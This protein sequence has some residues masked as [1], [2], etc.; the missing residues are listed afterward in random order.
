MREMY[1][2]TKK[3][4]IDEAYILAKYDRSSAQAQKRSLP[5]PRSSIGLKS[6]TGRAPI[7]YLSRTRAMAAVYAQAHAYGPFGQVPGGVEP[8]KFSRTLSERIFVGGRCC[9]AARLLS[10][11]DLSRR[12]RF[13]YQGSRGSNR[14]KAARRAELCCRPRHGRGNAGSDERRSHAGGIVCGYALQQVLHHSNAQVIFTQP[15]QGLT[16]AVSRTAARPVVEEPEP[17]PA[18]APVR[19]AVENGDAAAVSAAAKRVYPFV[20][21]LADKQSADI[22][23]DASTREAFVR[24]GDL[25]AKDVGAADIPGVVDRSEHRPCLR[26]SPTTAHRPSGSFPVTSSII[27]VKPSGFRWKPTTYWVNIWSLS[28]SREMASCNISS[29]RLRTGRP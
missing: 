29:P 1:P 14:R 9:P 18:V 16:R 15:R 2:N 20:T 11:S 10:A 4:H 26:A 8:S 23:W 28:T 5:R 25:L 27:K 21:V 6:S 3:D 19:V 7:F 17:L 22:V 24:G 13:L 12:R